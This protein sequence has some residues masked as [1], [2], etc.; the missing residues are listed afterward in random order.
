MVFNK[1]MPLALACILGTFTASAQERGRL[2]GT[3]PKVSKSMSA[4]YV[5]PH[6]GLFGGLANP[7]ASFD[8]SLEY[9]IDAGF[10]PWAPLGVG[11]EVSGLGSDRNQGSQPQDLNRTNVLVKG[12]Y[13]LGGTVPVIRYSYLGLGL[14]TVI[15]AS[16]Y[17]GWHSGIAP[18]LGFD[19]PLTAAPAEYFSLG[20]TA[21]Y[22]FVSGPS[23][24][25]V[26]VNGMVKYWF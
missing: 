2:E 8:T 13:N 22:V 10:Q 12:T 7:E 17:K 15:D 25:A 20:A 3:F 11:L 5:K 21:K 6:I 24:D 18:L 23:P 26:S 14:G 9:G 16:A 19:I 1:F 4:E